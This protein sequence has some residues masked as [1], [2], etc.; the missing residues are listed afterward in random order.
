MVALASDVD[1]RRSGIGGSD[2]AAVAGVSRWR[3]PM[4]V[5]LEKIGQAAPSIETERFRWGKLLEEPIAREFTHRYGIAVRRVNRT[6][7]AKSADWQ[8]AHVDR[9]VVGERAGLEIKTADVFAAD[10]FGEEDTDEVPP[11]YLLQCAHYMAV[12]GW[13]RW[14]LAVLIGY[15]L[16]RYIIPRDDDLI[17]QLTIIEDDFWHNHV[18]PRVPPAIDGSDASRRLLEARHADAGIEIEMSD[19]L[20]E[21]AL[22]YGTV[23]R[24]IKDAEE[25]KDALGNLIREQM[26]DGSKAR[27]GN[28]RIAWSNVTSRRLDVEALRAAHPEIAAEF[29]N[30]STA[31]QLRVT[32]KEEK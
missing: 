8:M 10:D 13:D 24:E 21:L 16:R 12:T 7:R 32:V 11:D 2:A 9:A 22:Q 18:V 3:T 6:L 29:T 23:Q 27:R 30:E 5:Y 19:R 20:Y 31:R 14:Y 28:V 15:R 17:G 25:R 4:D 26:G 1:V